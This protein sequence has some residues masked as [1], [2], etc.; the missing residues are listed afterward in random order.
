MI[1]TA[2][3]DGERHNICADSL[4]ELANRIRGKGQHIKVWAPSGMQLLDT[5]FGDGIR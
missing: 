5:K 1:Y 4:A 2:D 3:I